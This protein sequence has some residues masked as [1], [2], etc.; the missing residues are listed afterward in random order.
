MGTTER[1]HVE[2]Q[3]R[4]IKNITDLLTARLSLSFL[5]QCWLLWERQRGNTLRLRKGL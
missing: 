2:P 5:A 4:F 1:E 3:E